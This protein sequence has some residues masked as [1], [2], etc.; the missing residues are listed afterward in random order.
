MP[1]IAAAVAERARQDNVN[2]DLSSAENWLI[3]L[4]IIQL[5]KDAI[6]ENL[7]AKVRQ[8]HCPDYS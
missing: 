4:E 5:Y 7:N 3:R 1:K 8:P 6:A 2:I